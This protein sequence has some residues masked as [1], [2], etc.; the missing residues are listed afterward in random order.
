[1]ED[2]TKNSST[3]EKKSM[4]LNIGRNYYGDKFERFMKVGEIVDLIPSFKD[5][6][7]Q[8]KIKNPKTHLADI[9]QD[10][11]KEFC[12]PNGRLF[13]PY[14]AQVGFWRK[15]WDLDLMQQMQ[16]KELQIVERK[17]SINSSKHAMNKEI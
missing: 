6:Y 16:G 2:E 5:F 1:M 9:V 14:T 7:Y 17:I 8:E 3:N 11:N 4:T 15:K 10:F 12:E 13:H